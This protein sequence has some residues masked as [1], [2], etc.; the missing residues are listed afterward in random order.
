MKVRKATLA[1]AAVIAEFNRQLAWETEQTRLDPCRL[2]RG[3]RS[4]LRDP[5]KG[6]YFVADLGGAV[7]GQLLITYEWSDW[8]NGSF[9][10]IQSVYVAPAFRRRG[11]LRALFE[12]VHRLARS[13]RD[14]CGLRLYVD[15]RNRRAQT[16]YKKLGLAPSCYRVFETDFVLANMNP[17]RLQ[18]R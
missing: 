2:L 1:D 12:H 13:R 16:V 10:W 5:E 17:K 4:V 3:V 18:P 14:V 6:V 9:W 11:V 15:M 8:R 7:V